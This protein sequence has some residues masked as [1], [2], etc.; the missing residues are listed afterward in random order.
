MQNPR[1]QVTVYG[2]D[3]KEPDD[4]RLWG[5]VKQPAGHEAVGKKEREVAGCAALLVVQDGS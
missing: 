5:V 2:V 1:G 4:G 3:G